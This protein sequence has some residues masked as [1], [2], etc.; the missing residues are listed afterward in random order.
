MSRIGQQPIE[1][2][3]GVKVEIK[4]QNLV[5]VQGPKGTLEYNFDINSVNFELKEK[6]LL[7]IKNAKNPNASAMWGTARAIIS[8]M[9]TGVI[10]GFKK[11]LELQGVGYKMALQGNKIKFNLGFSH[12]IE[13][14]I[15][16]GLQANIEKNILTIEG[17]NKQA[18]GQ[19]AAE[20]RELRKVEPY[21]G[22]GFRYV[23]EQVIRK[24]GKKAVASE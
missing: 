15:P 4:D 21:K 18:V 16:Q 8:N 20:I 5:S 9:I 17:A 2:P 7:V 3:T 23:D 10:E 14:E 6:E 1:I 19:F 11:E 13:K 12:D 22:K 24:E